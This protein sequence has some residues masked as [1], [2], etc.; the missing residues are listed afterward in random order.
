MLLDEAKE[1]TKFQKD[2]SQSMSRST[3]SFT[4][5]M[6][7]VS[8]TLVQLD[9]SICQSVEMLSRA[10]IAQQQQHQQHQP[11][12]VNHNIFYQN[13]NLYS[14]MGMQHGALLPNDE[15]EI[16]VQQNVTSL[17]PTIQRQYPRPSLNE[18]QRFY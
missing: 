17:T 8:T 3:E 5:A 4:N 13:P 9:K 10:M 2:L 1:D 15:T 6:D 16:R 11:A 12:G 18:Q 7:G 14:P